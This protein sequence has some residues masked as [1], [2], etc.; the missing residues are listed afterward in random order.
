MLTCPPPE[1]CV[2][3]SGR[4]WLQLQTPYG[5]LLYLHRHAPGAVSDTF[6]PAPV[7]G[8]CRGLLCVEEGLGRSL[9]IILL[10]LANPAPPDW[11]ITCVPP[12]SIPCT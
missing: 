2:V 11:G 10:V 9:E 7:T 1:R 4:S 6:F 5:Q 8:T 3:L 12:S